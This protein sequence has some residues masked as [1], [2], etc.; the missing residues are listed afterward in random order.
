MILSHSKRWPRKCKYQVKAT[1]N[2][3][4]PFPGRGSSE[5][6]YS[7]GAWISRLAI[8]TAFEVDKHSSAGEMVQLLITH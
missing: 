7:S 2:S 5:K 8:R 4:E 3:R 6:G 1:Q